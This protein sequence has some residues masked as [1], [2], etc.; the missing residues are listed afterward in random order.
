MNTTE[1]IVEAYYRLCKNCFTYPDKKVASG[2]NRQLDLLAYCI[3][4]EEQLHIEAS[5]TH[6]L[7]WRATWPKLRD[8]FDRKFFGAPQRREGNNTDFSRGRNYFDA[9]QC[10]Y[11]SVG[12]C[13]SKLQRV[14]VTWVLPEDASFDD[15]LSTYCAS[16]GLPADG[17]RVV[18]FRDE[19]LPELSESVGRSNYG[20]DSLRTL[21]LI[22]QWHSQTD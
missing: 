8:A 2:N 11:E 12:F 14:W 13:L 21:S 6:E 16:R 1:K 15:H 5:V 18:S 4:T 10:T 17:I 20:D 9:I 7:S 3:P 22:Q 19:V